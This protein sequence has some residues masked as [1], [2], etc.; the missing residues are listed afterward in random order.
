MAEVITLDPDAVAT[1]RTALELNSG[2]ITVRYEGVDWGNADIEAVMADQERGSSPVDYRIPNRSIT[3]PLKVKASG[4]ITFDQARAQLQQKVSLLQ[5]EGGW[6]G[7]TISGGG[8]VYADVVNAGLTLSGGWLQENAGVDADAELRLEVIPDF[9]E[10][11]VTL[12]DHTETTLPEI[13]FTETTVGGDYPGRV[14]ILVDEDDGENQNSLIW[15]VR[16]RHY[17]ADSTA[18]AAYEAEE[19][20]ALDAASASSLSGASGG[21]A[22]IHSTIADDWTPV[23]GT[24]IGGSTYL[25]HTGAYRVW[26]RVYS[27]GGTMDARFVWD[28]GDLITP[29]ENDAT[30][31]PTVTGF[32]MVDLG[33]AR[34]DKVQTGSHRWGGQVQIRGTGGTVAVDRIW[35]FNTDE[36]Y[37]I[38][39][40]SATATT[41]SPFVARDAFAHTSGTL[42]GKVLPIG[43]TWTGAGDSDGFGINTTNHTA[44]RT[45]TSDTTG[46]GN[47]RFAIAG[48]AIY[49]A[50][51]VQ[52]DL[53]FSPASSGL[54]QVGVLARYT[55]TSNFAVAFIRKTGTDATPV[56]WMNVYIVV[57]GLTVETAGARAAYFSVPDTYHRVKFVV[58]VR[59]NYQVHW[60]LPDYGLEPSE[61]VS[62]YSA[63]LAAGGSLDD[64]K[65]G[66]YD[67]V[68]GA[69]PATR[70][71][72]NFLVT[73]PE[74][75]AALFASRSVELS[76]WSI[77]REDSGGNAYGPVSLV[78]GDLPRLPATGYDTRTTEVMVKLS[79][80][81]LSTAPDS[82][83]DDLSARLY[84]RPSWLYVPD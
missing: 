68:E 60:G 18:A 74:P 43:G 15:C 25:T 1:D 51:S 59:G 38:A 65:V 66:F 24:N 10:D 3:I 8:T 80:G 81:D 2:A 40:S 42:T 82:G 36:G 46:V 44:Q 75:D 48:T 54:F 76:T 83:I 69:F 78:T 21:T 62:G 72:D 41:L 11:E 16:S 20:E 30:T 17:S 19:L 35:F 26:A 12:S 6:I 64:G 22:V 45:A 39:Q 50:V 63:Y 32:Y 29:T 84:H 57:G 47:G 5:R 27:Y 37:G 73:A 34:L 14:R 79:R 31:I 71:F 4:T 53:T 23:V 13:T 70:Q 55:D 7:R 58:D 67:H 61:I 9:Y 28:V 56:W 52:A 33:E 77:N 49:D